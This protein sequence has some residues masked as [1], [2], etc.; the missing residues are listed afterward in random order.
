M[1]T[2]WH[3]MDCEARRDVGTAL[4]SAFTLASNKSAFGIPVETPDNLSCVTA[5]Q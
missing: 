4:A 3:D 1:R 5:L 2:R